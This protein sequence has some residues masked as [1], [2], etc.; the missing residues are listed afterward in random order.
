[1]RALAPPTLRDELVRPP[2]SRIPD[3]LPLLS[4]GRHRRRKDGVCLMEYTSILAGERFSDSPRCTDFVLAA[5]A[6]AVNDYSSDAARQQLA[7]LASELTSA[8]GAGAAARFA[9]GR[10]CLLTAVPYA[11]PVRRR[12]LVVGVLGLERAA[13]EEKIGWRADLTSV[14]TEWALLPYPADVCAAGQFLDEQ[15]VRP[16]EYVRR[17]LPTAVELAVATIAE[18]APRSDDVLARLLTDCVSDYRDDVAARRR[19]VPAG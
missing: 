2:M 19:L 4:P 18:R 5:I 15:G 8:R 14:E 16:A 10:R 3:F 1:M 11:T 9:I 17:G 7:V 13:A 12:V 6:R